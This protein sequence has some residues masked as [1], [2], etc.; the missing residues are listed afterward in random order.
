MASGSG[1]P[2]YQLMYA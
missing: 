1:L 2:R